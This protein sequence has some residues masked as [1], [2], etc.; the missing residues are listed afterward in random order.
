MVTTVELSMYPFREDYRDAIKGFIAKMNQCDGLKIA[1]GDTST[2]IIGECAHVMQTLSELFQ[3]SHGEH[4][5][6]VFVAKFIPG[7]EPG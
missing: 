6:A 3:W 2:V 1:T 4:G 7:Y 5:R